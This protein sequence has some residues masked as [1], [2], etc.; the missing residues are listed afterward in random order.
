[1]E[2][3]KEQGTGTGKKKTARNEWDR[4][5]AT[6]KEGPQKRKPVTLEKP[7]CY[8]ALSVGTPAAPE[9]SECDYWE[10][11]IRRDRGNRPGTR[12]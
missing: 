6:A 12:K 8:R 11:C 2:K 9:C 5:D 3:E 7:I 1:M 10:S 4:I